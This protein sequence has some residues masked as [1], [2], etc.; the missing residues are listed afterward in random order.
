[1]DNT[2]VGAS[3][4]ILSLLISEAAYSADGGEGKR[5]KGSKGREGESM[6]YR[7]LSVVMVTIQLAQADEGM[8]LLGA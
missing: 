7:C 5:S 2:G 1:M 3:N 6:K 8:I 4:N